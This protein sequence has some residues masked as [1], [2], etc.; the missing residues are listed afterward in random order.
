MC[1]GAHREL[2]GDV[3]VSVKLVEGNVVVQR[4]LCHSASSRKEGVALSKEVHSVAC[5]EGCR[6]DV[7]REEVC[8]DRRGAQR[9]IAVRLPQPRKLLCCHQQVCAP[10]LTLTFLSP[11]KQPCSDA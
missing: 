11:A 7:L 5:A 9:T 8:R 10:A 6:G 4:K 2:K 3:A 1:F